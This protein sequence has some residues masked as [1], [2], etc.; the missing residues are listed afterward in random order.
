M[1]LLN[2]RI[3]AENL[4]L[5]L[6][7]GRTKQVTFLTELKKTEVNIDK[8]KNFLFVK[9]TTKNIELYDITGYPNTNTEPWKIK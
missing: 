9:V 2:L 8:G 6:I 4:S 1:V 3:K 5:Y 7:Q